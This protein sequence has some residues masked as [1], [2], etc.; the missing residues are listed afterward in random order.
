MADVTDMLNNF[1]PN[2]VKTKPDDRE[3]CA[4][5]QQLLLFLHLHNFEEGR[6]GTADIQHSPLE[7]TPSG[8]ETLVALN[9]EELP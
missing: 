3:A 4:Q 2:I 9:K 5:K 1:N 7:L 8:L 6:E